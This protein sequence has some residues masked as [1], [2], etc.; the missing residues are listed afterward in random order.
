[1][2]KLNEYKKLQRNIAFVRLC[3]SD[4]HYQTYEGGEQILADQLAT[5]N[6]DLINLI[7]ETELEERGSYNE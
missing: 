4:P 3:L 1:M 6:A 7:H 5:K 2:S